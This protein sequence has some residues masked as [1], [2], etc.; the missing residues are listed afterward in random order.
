MISVQAEDFDIAR[1][2]A[3]LR[4]TSMNIGGIVTFTGLV[5][6]V[7]QS[8]S[9]E[10]EAIQEL[11]LEHY[12]GMTENQLGGIAAEANTRWELLACRVIHRIGALHPG[13]QIVFV[14]TA[15]IHR[16]SAFAAAEFIMDYLKTNAPFWKKQST[17]AGS[18]WI[19]QKASDDL[20]QQR[21]GK[22]E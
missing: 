22:G 5:R 19:E 21:W 2:Y 14:G 1:E 13:D 9:G 10:Q 20:A 3:L 11:F 4:R 6:E 17:A 7:Y 12:P 15:S 18:I 8:S 16:Q